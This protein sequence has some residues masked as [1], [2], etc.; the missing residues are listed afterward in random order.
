V[1]YH[2]RPHSVGWTLKLVIPATSRSPK[3]PRR[4]DEFTDRQSFAMVKEP[5]Y[6]GH[7]EPRPIT[8]NDYR[9]EQGLEEYDE[10]GRGWCQ[11]IL[12]KKSSGPTV[13]TRK[14]PNDQHKQID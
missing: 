1:V 2:P 8:I 3:A 12:N 10:L 11:L 9:K 5:H 4:S 13:G 14:D 6:H 7:N